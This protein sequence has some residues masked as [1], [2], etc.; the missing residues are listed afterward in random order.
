MRTRASPATTNP[1]ATR[2]IS[3]WVAAAGVAAAMILTAAPAAQAQ[4]NPAHK[5]LKAMSDYVAAQKVISLTYDS[6][7]E[8][9]TVELQKLQFT[10][11]GQLLLSRPGS[12]PRQPQRW[13][14]RC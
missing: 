7:I 3:R 14:F 8:V 5:I 11:S 1:S 6:D 4:E 2:G 9:L 12:S 13:L 10:S